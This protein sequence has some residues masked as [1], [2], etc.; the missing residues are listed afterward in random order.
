MP[1]KSN[2]I[3]YVRKNKIDQL[4]KYGFYKNTSYLWNNYTYIS[5]CNTFQNRIFV[6]KDLHM[7]FNNINSNVLKIIYDMIKDDIIYYE[8]VSK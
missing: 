8:R 1:K 2:V 4:E 6:C 5:T 3:F 7:Q